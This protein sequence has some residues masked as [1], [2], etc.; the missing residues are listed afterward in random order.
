MTSTLIV[1]VFSNETRAES[2]FPALNAMRRRDLYNLEETLLVTRPS[3]GDASF[4][5]LGTSGDIEAAIVGAGT[6]IEPGTNAGSETNM[7]PGIDTV[8]SLAR[9]IVEEASGEEESIAPVA[10]DLQNVGIDQHFVRA[11]AR[12]M[13]DEFSALFFLIRADSMGDATELNRVLSLFRGKTART[14][15][16]SQAEA[17]LSTCYG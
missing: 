14:S 1:I 11:V 17:Y 3:S 12:S 7:S 10:K 5:K 2:V 9:L 6:T 15:L 16:S 13:C 4:H 8:Q